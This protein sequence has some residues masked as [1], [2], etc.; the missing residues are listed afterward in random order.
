MEQIGFS[1]TAVSFAATLGLGVVSFIATLIA[2]AVIDQAGR[3]PLAVTG[4]FV[5]AA[6]LLAM[7][8]LT[9]APQEI[10]VARW[11]QVACLA[12]FVAAFG[13]TLG[14]ICGIV[15][16]EIYPQSI[17]GRATSLTSGMQS[18]FAIAFTLS[19]P[20]L[21]HTPGLTIT[22]LGYAA[23]GIL[24]ALYLLRALPETKAKSLEQITEF[25]NRRASS[26]QPSP[27]NFQSREDV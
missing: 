11:G 26:P 27:P 4:L 18:V 2:F 13:V 10:A 20:L 14:P 9:M 15:V 16:S 19:F 24:G 6:S 7:A 23:I 8:A 3:K 25:W 1:N 22:L 12:V 17:R 21:L 5:L